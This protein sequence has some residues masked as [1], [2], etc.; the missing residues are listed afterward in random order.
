MTVSEIQYLIASRLNKDETPEF[1]NSLLPS[2]YGTYAQ[3]IRRNHQKYG[4]QIYFERSVDIPLEESDL[5]DDCDVSGCLILRT[6]VDLPDTI[7]F[8]FQP[9]YNKVT[10]QNKGFGT[11]PVV[12]DWTTPENFSYQLYLPYVGN[13]PRYTV[14]NDRIYILNNKLIDHINVRA[15]WARP[16]QLKTL[17]C[18]DCNEEDLTIPDDIGKEIISILLKEE[19]G[20]LLPTSNNDDIRDNE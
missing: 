15:A 19:F 9:P 6:T 3:L 2:I 8:D 11:R 17:G 7:R 14:I 4:N 16:D 13:E 5:I 1:L 12:F 20:G 18:I 10:A